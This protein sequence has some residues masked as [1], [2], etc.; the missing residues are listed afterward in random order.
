MDAAAVSL[1]LELLASVVAGGA[2]GALM[3][4]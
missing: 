2:T 1:L 3:V 4:R